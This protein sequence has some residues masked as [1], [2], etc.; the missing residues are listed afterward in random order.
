MRVISCTA[1]ILSLVSLGCTATVNATGE[2]ENSSKRD[3]LTETFA[4]NFQM[5]QELEEEIKG[6]TNEYKEEREQEEDQNSH[7]DCDD[8]ED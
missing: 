3:S 5:N 8:D 2:V 7:C 6:A 4:P 1:A